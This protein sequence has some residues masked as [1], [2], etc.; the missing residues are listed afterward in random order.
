MTES[1]IINQLISNTFVEDVNELFGRAAE[2]GYSEVIKLLLK[3]SRVNPAHGDNY[4]ICASAENGHH[5]IV[6]LL[7]KDSRAHP[8]PE[9]NYCVYWS[10]KN[11]HYEVV[12][13]LLED[14]RVNPSTTEYTVTAIGNAAYHGNYKIVELLLKDPRVDPSIDENYA[15]RAASQKG[16]TEIVKLLL[17]D[18]R[19]DPSAANNFAIKWAAHHGHVE[20]VEL[21]LNSLKHRFNLEVYTSILSETPEKVKILLISHIIKYQWY[22]KEFLRERL[23]IDLAS[24]INHLIVTN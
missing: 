21:L 18:S 13:L 11:N 6:E 2:K 9:N 15:I 16:H 23:T 4:A 10:T 7:L 14:P 20:V 8:E 3:D 1:E 5:E 24:Q 17:V 12:K 22:L 19:V